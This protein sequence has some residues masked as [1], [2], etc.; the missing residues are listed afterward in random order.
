MADGRF[1]IFSGVW[2][3]RGGAG[4]SALPETG[5]DDTIVCADMGYEVCAGAGIRPAAVIGDFDSL[6]G[7][8]IAAID[9]AGIER[10]VYPVEK[11]DTDT[12]LCAKYGLARGFERFMIVGGIGEG[13]G[14]T[15]ANLQTLS[16]LMDMGCEAEILTEKERLFMTGGEAVFSGRPGAK[17]F[18]LSYS[19]RSTGVYIENARY[20][21]TDAVLTHSYPI[22]AG[23]EFINAAPVRVSVGQGRLLI[24]PDR[25]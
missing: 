21:L 23:N 4:G 25:F 10:V 12:M 11:D 22:G 15:M 5:P 17:F 2:P 16:F 3:G 13:F 7:E 24:I 20:G 14:H 19:E 18:V 9:A 1:V 6:S 8:R